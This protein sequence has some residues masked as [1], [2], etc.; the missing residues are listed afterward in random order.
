MSRIEE[1]RARE[2]AATP[3][4]YDYCEHCFHSG[5]RKFYVHPCPSCI[6]G[7]KN[8]FE[9][10]EGSEPPREDIPTAE[11]EKAWK[12]LHEEIA[13]EQERV[14]RIE[15]LEAE[16]ARYREAEKDGR[17]VVLP[18]KPNDIFW[19]RS[20]DSG[21][22]ELNIE[23]HDLSEHDDTYYETNCCAYWE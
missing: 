6:H 8:W 19:H 16:L 11:A 18:C 14:K 23:M 22:L 4:Q 2:Q 3:G 21:Q 17:L 10:A 15:Q 5:K 13:L 1:I 7:N 20:Y 9:L 12:Q